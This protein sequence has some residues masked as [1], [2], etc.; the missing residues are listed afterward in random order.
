MDFLIATHNNKKKN[1]LQRILAP[2]GISVFTADEKNIV[3][4]EVEETGETFEENAMLKA[5]SGCEDSGMPCVADDSGLCVDA[6]D[7]APGIYSARFG[8]EHGN[9]EKNNEKLLNL[10]K[11]VPPEKRTARFVSCVCCVFPDGRHLTVRGEVEGLIGY[12]P[13]GT[14]GFGYDPLFVVGDR[15]FAERTNEEKDELS[16]RGN[17]LRKLADELQDYLDYK[18]INEFIKSYGTNR[19]GVIYFEYQNAL[20]LVGL[21]KKENLPILGVDSFKV[22]D[23]KIQPFMEYSCDTSNGSFNYD[24]ISDFISSKKD[25]GLVFEI[26]LDR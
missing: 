16:H 23:D 2:L 25:L 5:V 18:E 19:N 13:K 21:C 11:D 3:L 4:R 17:A 6:L 24:Y 15:T 10:L 20:K 22:F 26:E 8:G 14:N 1:E 7:G 12:E 9:D